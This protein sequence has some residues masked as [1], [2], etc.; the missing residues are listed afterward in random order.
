MKQLKCLFVLLVIFVP[1]LMRAQ[2]KSFVPKKEGI[3][4]QL[5]LKVALPYRIINDSLAVIPYSGSSIPDYQI[6]IQRVSDL[7]IIYTNLSEVQS[8][9]DD[10]LVM[11]HLLQQ[12]DHFDLIKIGMDQHND[13]Y[14]RSDA[15]I[16][17]LNSKYMERL[18]R[19]VANVA[20]IVAGE[21]AQLHTNALK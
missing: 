5:L 12:A 7:C 2:T 19:Q 3:M 6:V 17:L 9:K 8:F 21:I 18:I 11:H 15:F 1:L 16:D 14:I 10:S 20:N 4:E 13:V